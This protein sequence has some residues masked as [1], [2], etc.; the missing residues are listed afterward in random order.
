[1]SEHEELLELLRITGPSV[2]LVQGRRRVKFISP[3]IAYSM[4]KMHPNRFEWGGSKRRVRLLR[5]TRESERIRV[6]VC[7]Y[8][9]AWRNQGAAVLM[10]SIEWLT[11]RRSG[12]ASA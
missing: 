7:E 5:D 10:P 2:K 3:Q 12:L 9:P 4:V 11:T 1:M 6:T 8:E